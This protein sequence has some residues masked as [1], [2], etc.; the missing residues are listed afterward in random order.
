[1]AYLY[2]FQGFSAKKEVMLSRTFSGI[3]DAKTSEK[4][5]LAVS[6]APKL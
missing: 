6:K 1:M 5:G 4:Y 3:S 2:P